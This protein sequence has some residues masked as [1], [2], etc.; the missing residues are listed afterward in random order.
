[1]E[2]NEVFFLCNG[3]GLFIEIFFFVEVSLNGIRLKNIRKW[4]IYV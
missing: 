4:F 1:M 2:K 3:N